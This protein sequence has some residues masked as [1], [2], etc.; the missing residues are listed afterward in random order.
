MALLRIFPARKYTKF[1][2]WDI[3]VTIASAF[4]ISRA[5]Q[6][7]GVADA[8]AE[9]AISLSHS[10]GPYLLLAVVFI[11][12]N[13]FTEIMTNNAAAALAFPIGL[14]ISEQLGVNPEPF[15]WPFAWRP[16]AVSARPSDIKPILS[17]K[18]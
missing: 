17:C 6:K 12:T 16:R 5:M 3:L 2:S 8:V 1:I 15:S 13:V 7:S 18:V 14:A 11:I 4:A 10:H 9:F